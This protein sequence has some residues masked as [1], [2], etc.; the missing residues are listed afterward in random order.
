[1]PEGMSWAT[2]QVH[3]LFLTDSGQDVTLGSNKGL[4]V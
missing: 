1:M 2:L 3:T 4:K